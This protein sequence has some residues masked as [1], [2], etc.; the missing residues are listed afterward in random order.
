MKK[1]SAAVVCALLLLANLI[2]YWP[3][4]AG[5]KIPGAN[6]VDGASPEAEVIRFGR[7]YQIGAVDLFTAGSE[8]GKGEVLAEEQVQ[9]EPANREVV[10]GVI[11]GRSA[12]QSAADLGESQRRP[13]QSARFELLSVAEIAGVKRGLV[14]YGGKHYFVSSG[15]VI[16]GQFVVQRID[17]KRVYI[18]SVTGSGSQ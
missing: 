9:P 7:S 13:A 17:D 15:D 2:K 8:A 6:S 18:N 16:D 5:R 12:G 4:S 11:G 14:K 3:E 10:S 1:I